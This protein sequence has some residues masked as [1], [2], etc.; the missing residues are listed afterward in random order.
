M[1]VGQDV[2]HV[3]GQMDSYA[4]ESFEVKIYSPEPIS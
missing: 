4:P 2:G 3:D 1:T